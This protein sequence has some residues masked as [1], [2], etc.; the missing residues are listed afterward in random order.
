MMDKYDFS[1]PHIRMKNLVDR[2]RMDEEWW[3]LLSMV[4]VIYPIVALL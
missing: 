1:M 4:V 2:A 3:I